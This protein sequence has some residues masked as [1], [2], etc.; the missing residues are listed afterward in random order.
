MFMIDGIKIRKLRLSDIDIMYSWE[1]CETFRYLCGSTQLPNYEIYYKRFENYIKYGKETLYLFAIEVNNEVVGRVELG[2]VDYNNKSGAVGIVIGKELHR[3]CGYG[4]K[5]LLL[6]LNFAFNELNLN[7]VF[8]EVY[9][10]NMASQNLMER[11]GFYLEGTMRQNEFHFGK[12]I[13]MLLY[14]FLSQEFNL[15]YEMINNDIVYENNNLSNS[16]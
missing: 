7:R 14:S 5:A 9:S 16:R 8:T 10:F 12:Y 6:I 13:D 11:V 2:R 15:R 4:T 1:E 3:N